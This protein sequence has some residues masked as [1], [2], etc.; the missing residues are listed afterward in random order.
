MSF[1]LVGSATICGGAARDRTVSG[2]ARD[3]TASGAACDRTASGLCT[4]SAAMKPKRWSISALPQL[5]AR[6]ATT[7]SQLFVT[8]MEAALPVR[9]GLGAADGQRVG[10]RSRDRAQCTRNRSAQT[11]QRIDEAGSDH[12]S[13]ELVPENWLRDGVCSVGVP[14]LY[15]KYPCPYRVRDSYGIVTIQL[16]QSTV[17]CRLII[18]QSSNKLASDTA[19]GGRVRVRGCVG[20]D[21]WTGW[22]AVWCMCGSCVVCVCGAC[23]AC[24]WRVV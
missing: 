23:R 10:A 14:T 19:Y 11:A 21:S 16:A 3:R 24:V 8:L 13:R 7:R 17:A 15:T 5:L 4:L 1:G 2:A 12:C 9:G 22:T 18:D 20:V 6:F